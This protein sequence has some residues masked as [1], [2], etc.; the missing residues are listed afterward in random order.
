MKSS[1]DATRLN[2]V[3]PDLPVD[4]TAL[5]VLRAEAFPDAPP[6]AWLDAPDAEAE[7]DRRV[8]SGA[9]SE[10]SARIARTYATEGY[11]VL[12]GFFEPARLDAVWAAYEAALAD[13]RVAV[14]LEPIAPEDT[15]PGR[16]LNP[17][18]A[19]PEIAAMLHDPALVAVVAMLFDARVRPFQTIIGHK[20]SQQREHSDSIHMTTYPLGYLAGAWIAFEEIHPESGPLVYYPRSHRL[21]YLFSHDVGI[22]VQDFQVSGYHSY[23]ER[24][25]PALAEMLAREGFEARSFQARKGDVLLWHANVVHAGSPR[26]D[27]RLS[28]KALVCHYFADG[29]V[30]YHDLAAARADFGPAS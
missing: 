18:F 16:A 22:S 23:H 13:G 17:H 20:G 7:I 15:L 14:P 2:P 10:E 28:R 6:A 3:V 9:L 12:E 30:C 19:V 27:P 29:C 4:A 24:Y 1:L 5:P 25:E 8:A 21:P 11:A 26:R